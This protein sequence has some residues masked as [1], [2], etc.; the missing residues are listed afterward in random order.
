MRQTD[1]CAHL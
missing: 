1:H